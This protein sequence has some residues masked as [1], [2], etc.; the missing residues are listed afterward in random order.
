MQRFM[1]LMQNMGFLALSQLIIKI[2]NF[3]LLPLYTN[4]LTTTEYGTYDIFNTTIAL[5]IPF[6]TLNIKESTIRFALSEDYEKD[7]ILSIS[8]KYFL[9]SLVPFGIFMAVNHVTGF[10]SSMDEYM[11]LILLMYISQVLNGI[12]TNFIR[13]LDRLKDIAVSSVVC[14]LSI[15]LLNIV[16]LVPL[17]MGLPGYFLAN[18]I[19]PLV[20]T[21]YLFILV[22]GWRFV[23]FSSINKRTQ[24][25]MVSYSMPMIANS[26]AWWINSVSDR[27]VVI[28]ICGA[29]AN[30][31]Y[32]VAN[33]IPTIVDTFQGIFSQAWTLSAVKEFDPE[34][35]NGF[36]SNMYSLYNMSM[37]IM[38][39]A[40]IVVSRILSRFLYSKDFFEA[41]KYVPFLTIAVL[42]GAIA[43]YCGA[44]FSAA[45]DSKMY[46][47]STTVGAVVNIVLNIIL[48]MPFGPLGAA[49]STA[50]SYFII[51]LVRLKTARKYVNLKIDFLRDSIA[52]GILALQSALLLAM[53]K[54][55][56]LLYSLEIG[57]WLVLLFLFK[58]QLLMLKEKGVK[59]IGEKR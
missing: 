41:W 26:T 39:S 18:S 23:K 22:K 6:L 56:I 19:G 38:S 53:A 50:I 5:L 40:L 27:Y 44:I 35:K 55:T 10:S 25:E 8:L 47:I 14:S 45:K 54:D 37:T 9:A 30:G 33:K 36:F 2:I 17:K 13:G 12:V 20:Q 1:Y 32:S 21:M 16:M 42:F 3:L 7:E 58:N 24:K 52:Y 49:I 43:G 48:V 28:W 34:D 31:I 46:A 15:I 11:W 4:I 51:Y 57:L 59:L 29:A